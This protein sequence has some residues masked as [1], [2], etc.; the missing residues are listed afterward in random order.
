VSST[1][2]TL[3]VALAVFPAA[4]VAV[5]VSV[6]VPTGNTFPAG[7]PLTA[8]VTL[9]QLSVA[10]A[11][12]RLA[13]LTTALHPVAPAP[14]VT[15]TA[16]GAATVGFSVSLMVTDCIAVA[17]FPAASRAVQVTVVVPFG[18]LA[19]ASFVTVT[20]EQLSLAVGVPRA[21]CARLR[22]QVPGSVPRVTAA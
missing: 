14:V 18:K 15:L 4:S 20:P 8:T 5:Q 11:I 6:V 1:T 7:T 2:V 17:A 22:P 3:C 9:G 12:P 10:V 19:G 13:V 21:T 16:A